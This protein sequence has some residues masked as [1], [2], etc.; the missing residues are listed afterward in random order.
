MVRF[1][2]EVD[3]FLPKRKGKVAHSSC[4]MTCYDLFFPL[5][6]QVAR[7]FYPKKC[8]TALRVV[9]CVTHGWIFVQAEVGQPAAFL[10][11]IAGQER[12]YPGIISL[13]R[14][15]KYIWA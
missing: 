9:T 10:K 2:W 8:L 7:I 13:A 15:G 6:S 3:G 5:D 4:V 14:L 11:M 12:L 1:S